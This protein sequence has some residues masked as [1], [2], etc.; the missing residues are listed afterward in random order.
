MLIQKRKIAIIDKKEKEKKRKGK[1]KEKEKRGKHVME[2]Q[3][4]KHFISFLSFF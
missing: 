3:T 4:R 1:G 2:V